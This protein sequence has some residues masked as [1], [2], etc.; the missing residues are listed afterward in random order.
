M[1]KIIALSIAL[2]L[3]VC[4][5]VSA[6]AAGV[7]L[8][9][10]KVKVN[11]G[12]EVTVTLTLDET[13]ENVV[14]FEY[15][16]YFD[17]SKFEL[18]GSANGTAHANMIRSN[19]KQDKVGTCYAVNVIDPSSEGL[20]ISAGTVYTL[21]FRALKAGSASFN[22]VS[23]GVYDPSFHKLDVPAIGSVTVKVPCQEHTWDAGKVT[24]QKDCV[25]DEIT[26]YTC[27]V[28]GET[29]TEVTAKAT[30]HSYG[31]WVVDKAASCTETGVKSQTCTVC[32]DKK[33][34]AIPAKG[35]TPG[36]WVETK[37][38]TCTE[39][40]ERTK[41]C[42]V[43]GS[44]LETE[45]IPAKG[46]TPD[47]N[48]TIVKEPTCEEPGLLEGKCSVCGE[49]LKNEPIPALGH[50]YK[51]VEE[52]AP[53]CTEKGYKKYVCT[54]DESH[55]KTETLEALG[56]KWGAWKEDKDNGKHVHTCEVCGET[57][58]A[59]H[60]WDAGHVTIPAT[61]VTEGE[62]TFACKDCKAA[63]VEVIPAT[64]VHDYT[65]HYEE[66]EDGKTHTA[67]CACGDS[68]VENHDF[69]INGEVTVKP[70]AST[71]GKQ[72]MLCV[73]GAKTVV[74]LPKTAELDDVPKTGDMTGQLVLGGMAVV[75]VLA[76]AYYIL[77]RKLAR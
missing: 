9:A 1:K 22:I 36:P 47:Q 34:E 43:C 71:E 27:T 3:V 38:P 60:N 53:T 61:C 66:N 10:N 49:T 11:P 55:T 56:H 23:K 70:T 46:H 69:S 58:S 63:K 73:C 4:F 68:K 62:K 54:R 32:G 44:V 20:T 72:E 16:V 35:H 7:T 15:Y 57:E 52:K 30:G 45:T 65:D 6:S 39:A 5:A 77:R 67:F 8:S 21:T 26:T 33:T 29:K 12:D 17:S 2:M 31:D 40:G 14:S 24:Q 48:A 51:L 74:T 25:K 59:N 13:L 64:G 19:L 76:C 42:T 41:S 37:A 18:S 75:A 28:C 50:D